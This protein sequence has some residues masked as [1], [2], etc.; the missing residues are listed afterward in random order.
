MLEAIGPGHPQTIQGV[1]ITA[2]LAISVA[3]AVIAVIT[4]RKGGIMHF[5]AGVVGGLLLGLSMSGHIHIITKY[6]TTGNPLP[7]YIITGAW[8]IAALITSIMSGPGGAE[9]G[10]E[11]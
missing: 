6:F 3:L 9:G 5:V 11:E 2:G 8:F 10:P 4:W 7:T 1:T